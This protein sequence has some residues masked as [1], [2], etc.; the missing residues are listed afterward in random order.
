MKKDKLKIVHVTEDMKIGGQERV[1]EDI[2]NN[3]DSNIFE[4]QLLCLTH[5]GIIADRLEKNGIKVT[6]LDIEN[7][8]S[9]SSIKKTISWFKNEEIDIVHTHGFSSGVIGRI[10]A[11]FAGVS[12]IYAHIHTMSD[13]LS[14]KHVLKEKL[15]SFITTKIITVSD[16][17]NNSYKNKTHINLKK[18]IMIYNG[19]N[20]PLHRKFDGKE[21]LKKRY[22]IPENK[23]VIGNVA[24][25]TKHKAHEFL[26]EAVKDIDDVYILIVG[27]GK[28]KM[29]LA[30]LALK[31]GI[32]KRVRLVGN[33]EDIF[34]FI[35]IM[36][37]FVLS[38]IREGHP[39]SL[40]EAMGFKKPV[41]ATDVGGVNEIIENGINGIII[42]PKNSKKIEESINL[43]ISDKKLCEK[44]GD[45]GKETYINRFTLKKM[46]DRLTKLYES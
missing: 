40:I 8:N 27:D 39:L 7:Y 15:L 33:Q 17:V 26:F 9:I 42:P 46:I 35:N 29:K 43:L 6:I 4:V 11:F 30:E 31:L 28:E 23:T 2:L 37:I 1:I 22:D 24:S 44:F 38:S 16:S 32:E 19:L 34:P 45:N 25:L 3:L 13:D 18:L 14:F 21:N 5:G 41:I 36:D 12:N 10:A 20:L